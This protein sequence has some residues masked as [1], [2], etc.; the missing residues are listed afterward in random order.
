MKSFILNSVIFFTLG[1]IAT[2]AVF[3]L[4]NRNS[5]TLDDLYSLKSTEKTV[6]ESVAEAKQIQE[7]LEKIP[8]A[9]IPLASMR[10]NDTQKS[11]LQKVGIDT[12]S[13]V[14]TKGMVACS[15]KKLGAQ[16]TQALIEGN[17]PSII[18]MTTLTPCLKSSE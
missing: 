11:A 17:S 1:A 18:E 7:T 8:D 15:V 3:Y 2:V 9:G 13:F 14:I 10:L 4:I 12:Q 6:E 16:R 5:F